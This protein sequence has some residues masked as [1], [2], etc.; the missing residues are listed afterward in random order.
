MRITFCLLLIIFLFTQCG[1]KYKSVYY[2]NKNSGPSFNIPKNPDKVNSLLIINYSDSVFPISGL[3]KL[4]NLSSIEIMAGK[5]LQ[6]L[7]SINGFGN[8]SKI[9]FRAY[10]FC[11]TISSRVKLN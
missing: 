4:T 2:W 10:P 5:S 9:I 6:V 7:P 1:V 8:L 3:M 11:E